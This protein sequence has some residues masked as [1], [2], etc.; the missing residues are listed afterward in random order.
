MVKNNIYNPI[1]HARQAKF[2]ED[3]K[4]IDTKIKH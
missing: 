4:I 2:A 1:L 3:C